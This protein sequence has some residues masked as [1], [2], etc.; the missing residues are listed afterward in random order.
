LVRDADRYRPNVAVILAN[1][2]AQVLLARRSIPADAWQFPQ[3]GVGKG[4]SPEQALYRE[5]LEEVG[6]QRHL[7]RRVAST[8]RWRTYRIPAALSQRPD[9][10]AFIGQRQKWYLLEFLGTDEDIRLDREAAPEFDAWQWVSYWYPLRT[11]VNF[12][13][14]VY[15]GAMKELAPHLVN[16]H[17]C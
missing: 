15:A 8:R 6:L 3:G 7:V 16:I 9:L 2:K 14:Q 4:E 13:R 1:R 5:L 12:K 10:K 17:S 11:I